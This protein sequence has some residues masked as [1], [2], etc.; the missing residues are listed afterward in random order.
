MAQTGSADFLF[1]KFNATGVAVGDITVDQTIAGRTL[2]AQTGTFNGDGTGLFSFGIGCTPVDPQTCPNGITTSHSD[3]TFHV[4]NALI[5]DFTTPNNLGNLFVAD[6]GNS[7]NGAT[8]PIDAS[9]SSF[10]PTC[11]PDQQLF[12]APEPT[13]LILLGSGLLAAT[14]GLRRFKR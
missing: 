6:I 7:T 4:A 9:P 14:R 1:F 10:C 2:V 3:I 13:S 8:G 5:S 12:P 11:T